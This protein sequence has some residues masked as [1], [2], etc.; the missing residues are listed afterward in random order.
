MPCLFAAG[1]AA[2]APGSMLTPC[3]PSS[4]FS[5]LSFFLDLRS[6]SFSPPATG[7]RASRRAAKPQH[8]GRAGRQLG[9]PPAKQHAPRISGSRHGEPPR[10]GGRA[11]TAL[12]AFKPHGAHHGPLHAP[13]LSLRSQFG[14][15]LSGPDTDSKS[16]SSLALRRHKSPS[17]ALR[18]CLPLLSLPFVV[19]RPGLILFP[20]Y[21]SQ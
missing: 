2:L 12:P 3:F 5:F 13:F 4:P 19:L 11:S 17:R 16:M 9:N 15:A 1:C 7:R 10:A 14:A 20:T 18:R 6:S 21:P 8:G